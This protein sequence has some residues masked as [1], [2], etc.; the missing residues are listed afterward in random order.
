MDV[1]TA[2]K[3]SQ[4]LDKQLEKN[5]WSLQD[6]CTMLGGIPKSVGSKIKTGKHTL[7]PQ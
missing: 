4:F 7:K 1:A 6:L 3:L 2:Q 5:G